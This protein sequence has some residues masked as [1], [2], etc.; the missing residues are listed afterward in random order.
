MSEES[1]RR[2]YVW[3]LA[4]HG[5][6]G[7]I[8]RVQRI[9]HV[10]YIPKPSRLTFGETFKVV[11]IACGYGFTSFAV[12]SKDNNIVYGSGINTDSQIGKLHINILHLLWKRKFYYL[13]KGLKL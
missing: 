7:T 12:R 1:D 9:D 6:L 13:K 2:V 10:A 8:D 5:A 3:G 11:D 4:E